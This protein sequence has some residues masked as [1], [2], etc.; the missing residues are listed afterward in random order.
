MFSGKVTVYL[1]SRDFI[2]HVGAQTNPVEGVIVVEDNYLQ[3]R[4]VYARVAV[5]YRYGR[6]GDEMMGLSFS[7]E[8][9][10]VNTEVGPGCNEFNKP[11]EIQD[12]LIK[13]LGANTHPFKVELPNNAPASV[14]L[15]GG[16][17]CEV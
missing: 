3:G 14:T 12:R 15:E 2:D 13:K 4:K 1:S 8:F 16:D 10:L 17:E 11:S 7:K 6:E 9:I 5:T